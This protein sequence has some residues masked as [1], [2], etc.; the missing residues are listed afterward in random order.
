MGAK[1]VTTHGRATITEVAVVQ[2]STGLGV[3]REQAVHSS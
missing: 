2:V 1:R 3:A